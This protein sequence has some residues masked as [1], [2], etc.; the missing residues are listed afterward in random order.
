MPSPLATRYRQILQGPHTAAELQAQAVNALLWS[1]RS[2]ETRLRDERENLAHWF[3]LGQSSPDAA[4]QRR[5]YAMVVAVLATVSPSTFERAQRETLSPSVDLNQAL[6]Y[7]GFDPAS[8]LSTGLRTLGA[9]ALRVAV[10]MARSLSRLDEA[11][12]SAAQRLLTVDSIKALALVLAG[13]V[14]A[15]VVGGP[16][17]MAVNAI[18]VVYGVVGLWEEAKRLAG[19]LRA[20]LQTAYDAKNDADLDAAA[21]H[22]AQ[23]L[24]GGLV[25]SLEVWIT[26]RAFR[27]VETTIARRVPTPE[28]L[29]VEY[30]RAL[31]ER[32]A[33]KRSTV[34]RVAEAVVSGAR[35]EGV[36]RASDDLPSVAAVG[37]GV[38]AA[39]GTVALMG[40]ALADRTSA[41]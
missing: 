27:A 37:L 33:R 9:V 17:G 30:E 20:F 15:T 25:T 3:S 14:L 22:F 35:G 19:E 1:M 23:A 18:L 26:H 6:F 21:G 24:A 32:E 34:E 38:V 7:R 13:W 12:W 31:R 16:L 4:G 28:R 40:W 39:V 11:T 41:S 36:R 5:N 2:S 8:P 29:R 10:A